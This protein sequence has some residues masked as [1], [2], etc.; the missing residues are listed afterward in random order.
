MERMENE[1]L[2][3]RVM[4]AKVNGRG[5]RGR[6]RLGWIDGVRKALQ[7]RGMDV[8][9]ARERAKDRNDRRAIVRRV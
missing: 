1:R 2:L 5:V 3:K 6:P 8:R 9:E 4:N 7:E